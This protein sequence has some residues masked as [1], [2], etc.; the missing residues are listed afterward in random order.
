[1]EGWVLLVKDCSHSAMVK[2]P[3]WPHRVPHGQ[4]LSVLINGSQGR[5]DT[6][7]KIQ[8]WDPKC[9][10]R[11]GQK[12]SRKLPSA[13]TFKRLMALM[14]SRETFPNIGKRGELKVNFYIVTRDGLVLSFFV[15]VFNFVRAALSPMRLRLS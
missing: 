12:E 5:E 10:S 7:Q 9:I 1:M 2:S 14:I 15:F 3:R 6:S 4:E 11:G 8:K 13:F